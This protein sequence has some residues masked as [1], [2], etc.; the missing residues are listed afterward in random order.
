MRSAAIALLIIAIAAL[1][2]AQVNS[3]GADSASQVVFKKLVFPVISNLMIATA[4]AGRP[5][6][7]GDVVLQVSVH[8]D[9]SVESVTLV[10]GDRWL[11][12]AAIES[13][14]QS[15]FECHG[16]KEP[17]EKSLTYSFKLSPVQ[18]GPC[19]CTSG[20]P[21]SQ[22]PAPEVSEANGHVTFIA[23]PI[24]VCPDACTQAW[25]ASHSRVRSPQCLYLWKCGKRRVF[26]M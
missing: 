18:A 25:A 2:P 19:C 13:A 12:Q 1:A 11:T 5:A 17:V 10:S 20:H 26:V 14:R 9:G 7:A 24:C 21:D 15:Q 16:C 4:T 22:I 6:D 8:P 3:S 23:S